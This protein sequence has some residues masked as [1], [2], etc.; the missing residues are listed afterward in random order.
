MCQFTGYRGYRKLCRL[1]VRSCTITN[2]TN[3]KLPSGPLFVFPSRLKKLR[4]DGNVSKQNLLNI[5]NQCRDMDHLSVTHQTMGIPELFYDPHIKECL[6]NNLQHVTKLDVQLLR[7]PMADPFITNPN[8][9]IMLT[10]YFPSLKSFKLCFSLWGNYVKILHFLKKHAST[11]QELELLVGDSVDAKNTKIFLQSNRSQDRRVREIVD[12]KVLSSL[13]L[14]KFILRDDVLNTNPT[15]ALFFLEILEQLTTL[16]VF[17]FYSPG[18]ITLQNVQS[19]VSN[20]E[21]TLEEFIISNIKKPA[22]PVAENLNNHD[23]DDENDQ[24]INFPLDMSIFQRCGKLKRLELSCNT[25]HKTAGVQAT[26]FKLSNLHLISDAIERVCLTG[27]QID[28]QELVHWSENSAMNLKELCIADAGS[29]IKYSILLGCVL[30]NCTQLTYLNVRPTVAKI[31]NVVD[32]AERLSELNELTKLYNHFIGTPFDEDD[33]DGFEVTKIS[34]T[35]RK[36]VQ[37]NIQYCI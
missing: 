9:D 23:D 14:T 27:F 6:R 24:G 25:C 16:K 37:E 7:Y 36:W 10:N 11:L 30:K 34:D 18:E 33:L 32:E 22:A 3:P 35:S 17:Q 29:V 20:N 8:M 1:H 12:I 15:V 31:D 28:L 21:N 5:L 2:L 4:L 19:I 26:C 13:K